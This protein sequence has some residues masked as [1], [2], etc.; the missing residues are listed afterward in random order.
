MSG[1]SLV[2]GATVREC[3]LSA[4]MVVAM[5]LIVGCGGIVLM[6]IVAADRRESRTSLDRE[7]WSGFET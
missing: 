5:L 4:G 7:V 1:G 6:A 3:G 2:I